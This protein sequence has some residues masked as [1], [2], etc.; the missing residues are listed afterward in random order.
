MVAGAFL[1]MFGRAGGQ[2]T[3]LVPISQTIPLAV[4]AA[5][6]CLATPSDGPRGLGASRVVRPH[7]TS[8][9]GSRPSRLGCGISGVRT[10][11]SIQKTETKI[12]TQGNTKNI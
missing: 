10:W 6:L 11:I 4:G 7:W 1:E 9:H 5:T 8:F 12:K 2:R 3:V